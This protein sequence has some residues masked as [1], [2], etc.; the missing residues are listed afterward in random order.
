MATSPGPDGPRPVGR[1][2][3][4]ELD[5]L[6]AVAAGVVLFHHF[7]LFPFEHGGF[8]GVDLFLGLSGFLITGILLGEIARSGSIRLG[9][10]YRRRAFRLLPALFLLLVV[11]LLAGWLVPSVDPDGLMPQSAAAA[12]LYISNWVVA[13]DWFS[14]YPLQHTWSLAIEE[15]FYL[16]WPFALIGV[17]RLGGRTGGASGTLVVL[18]ALFL[19]TWAWRASMHDEPSGRVYNGLDTRGTTLLAGAALAAALANPSI[20]RALDGRP[21]AVLAAGTAAAGYLLV[22]FVL[23]T[24]SPDYGTRWALITDVAV[25]GVVGACV[26]LSGHPLLRPLRFPLVLWAGRRSY[27]IYLWH[28]FILTSVGRGV[29]P[30]DGHPQLIAQIALT[31]VAA[32]V[33]YRFVERPLL[34]AERRW[35]PQGQRAPEPA[36]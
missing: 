30:I 20:R 32:E 5:G 8:L 9:A 35:F 12:A 31:L 23:L 6:R 22:G 10:F 19:L 24:W 34:E 2:Y 28:W 25:V 36:T 29:L 27:G 16:L 18:L 13:F 1:P 7:D 26:L 17:V 14:I 11:A 33:S 3:W 15:Q 21:R 4:P